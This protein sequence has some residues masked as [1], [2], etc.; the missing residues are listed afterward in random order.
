MTSKIDELFEKKKSANTH[1]FEFISVDTWYLM[2]DLV[3]D[4]KYKRGD[5]FYKYEQELKALKDNKDKQ[6]PIICVKNN[7]L[8]VTFVVTHA[9]LL[10]KRHAKRASAVRIASISRAFCSC[11]ANGPDAPGD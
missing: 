9:K 4:V 6:N 10:N 1:Y 7:I 3:I 8:H 5:N 2:S 11:A